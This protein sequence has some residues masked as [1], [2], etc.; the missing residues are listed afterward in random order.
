VLGCQLC[1]AAAGLLIPLTGK[2]FGLL[3]FVVGTFALIAGVVASN[4]IYAGWRQGYCPPELLGRMSASASVVGYST[5]ALGGILGGALGSAVGVR[6]TM[7]AM[8]VLLVLST[9]ILLASPI[10]TRRDFPSARDSHVPQPCDELGRA[11]HRHDRAEVE[12]VQA[13][14]ADHQA[15]VR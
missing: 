2:G 5:T 7:W 13:A 11:V 4:V 15:G 1:A 14:G 3:C 6:P 12:V 10:R 8:T 9:S